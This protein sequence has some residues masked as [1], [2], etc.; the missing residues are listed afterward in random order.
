MTTL[1]KRISI[2]VDSN[3]DRGEEMENGKSV[4]KN[5][6]DMITDPDK[7]FNNVDRASVIF[8][9]L[10]DETRMKIILALSYGELC[11]NHICEIAGGKQSAISQHLRRLKDNN[12][13]KSRKYGN[14]VLYSLADNHISEIVKQCLEHLNCKND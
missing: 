3:I 8:S 11:V 7:F 1:S 5:L 12:I 6:L 2:L 4:H 10:G 14:L 9:L 13:V